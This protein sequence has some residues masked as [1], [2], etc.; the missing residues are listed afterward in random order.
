M[1][2][3]RF[4]LI[5]FVI[6]VFL[7]LSV[8]TY[9]DPYFPQ[10]E[11][12]VLNVGFYEMQGAQEIDEQGNLSGFYYDYLQAIMQ[13][14]PWDLHFI[15]KC[16]WNSCL[17]ML[18]TG[19]IDILCGVQK[20]PEREKFYDFSE[21]SSITFYSSIFVNKNNSQ[22]PYNDFQSLDGLTVGVISNSART[23]YFF[24]FCKEN[25]FSMK[26]TLFIKKCGDIDLYYI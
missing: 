3:K 15:T 14:S 12:K 9:A 17:E 23:D 8:N 11:K 24:E 13:Y 22:I 16:D 25:N 2:G 21:S 1:L 10:I 19:E 26:P 6:F 20:N 4:F 18:K 5:F 7:F